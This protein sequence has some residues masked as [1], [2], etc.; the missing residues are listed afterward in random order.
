[1]K[2][3]IRKIVSIFWGAIFGVVGYKI[4]IIFLDGSFLWA[5]I[6]T[7]S[8]LVA[9]AVDKS[10]LEN[11]NNEMLHEKLIVDMEKVEKKKKKR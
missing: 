9:S 6:I 4:L 10:I 3:W 8:V 11:E 1:M 7:L 2:N 5:I